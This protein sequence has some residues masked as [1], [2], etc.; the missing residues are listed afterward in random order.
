LYTLQIRHDIEVG[1]KDSEAGNVLDS[2]ELR[3]QLFEVIRAKLIQAE[4]SGFTDQSPGDLLKEIKD[5]VGRD[6]AKER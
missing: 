3:R 4:T 6:W 2:D 1:L 5:G